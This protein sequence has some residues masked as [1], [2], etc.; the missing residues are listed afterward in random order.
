MPVPKTKKSN[1][2]GIYVKTEIRSS[3]F[4]QI[5]SLRKKIGIVNSKD[6][7]VKVIVAK[8]LQ[9]RLLYLTLNQW[10]STGENCQCLEIAL[11][12]SSVDRWDA[13]GIWQIEVKDTVNTLH[14]HTAPTTTK[15]IWLHMFNWAK[16]EKPWAG[17]I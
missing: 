11:V 14:A 10:F 1:F 9:N 2:R 8:V 15:I 16:V 5:Y 7:C 6:Y 17:H 3:P 4:G 12:L 13:T